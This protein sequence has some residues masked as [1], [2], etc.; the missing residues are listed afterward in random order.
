MFIHFT[1]ILKVQFYLFHILF[2]NIIAIS[3]CDT[4]PGRKYSFI[5]NLASCI[6]VRSLYMKGI[7]FMPVLEEWRFPAYSDMKAYINK[8]KFLKNHFTFKKY[9]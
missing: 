8:K 7:G 1:K 5:V 9:T 4:L 2:E 3:K 6:Y